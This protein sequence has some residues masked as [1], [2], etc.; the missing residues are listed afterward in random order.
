[1]SE[2]LRFINLLAEK[3]MTYIVTLREFVY[4]LA[5]RCAIL[6]CVR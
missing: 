2:Q 5:Q 6:N 1:L 3:L 4:Y